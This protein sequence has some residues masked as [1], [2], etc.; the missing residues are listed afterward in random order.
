MGDWYEI[1]IMVGLGVAAGIAFAGILAG[2]RF[3]VASTLLGSI[4][5]GV[6][7]G[8]LLNGWLGAA[9]GVVGAVVGSVSAAMVVRGA[10]KRGATA[11]GTALLLFAAAI[12]VAML[13]LIPV[14]GYIE[15]V[16]LPGLA[17][18]RSRRGPD[19]YAGLRSLAK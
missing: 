15:A 5:V 19:K 13:A 18:R 4:V 11:G 9:G 7:V 2:L 10:G 1:G 14:V 8:L 17:A 16:V 3:G 6:V 12:L